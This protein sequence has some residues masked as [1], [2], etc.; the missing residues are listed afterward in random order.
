MIYQ[1]NIKKWFIRNL[2]L[3]CPSEEIKITKLDKE[4][5]SLAM[6]KLAK[7][8]LREFTKH[9]N[10][11]KFKAIKKKQVAKQRLESQKAID[12]SIE[13]AGQRGMKWLREANRISARPGDDTFIAISLPA[14]V[15]S[16]FTPQ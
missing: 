14:H 13:D 15:D 8:R 5:I 9:G 7:Q 12:K 10:S 11:E 2:D 3:I 6:Q 16:N 1:T 4:T